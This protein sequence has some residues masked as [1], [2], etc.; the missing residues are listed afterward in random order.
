MKKRKLRKKRS[1]IDIAIRIVAKI[2]MLY[3]RIFT[4]IEE[5][6]YVLVSFAT[7]ID[8]VVRFTNRTVIS[9]APMWFEADYYSRKTVYL[10]PFE[11]DSWVIPLVVATIVSYIVCRV[12]EYLMEN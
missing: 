5:I 7:T 8:V 9:T 10:E 2:L 6:V 4:K 11:L 12:V 1:K 3:T